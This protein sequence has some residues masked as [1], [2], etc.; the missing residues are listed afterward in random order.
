MR[1]LFAGMLLAASM[2]ASAQVTTECTT[3]AGITRCDTQRNGS[4]P[5]DQSE[6]LRRGMDLVPEYKGTSDAERRQQRAEAL[7]RQV[8]KLVAG[9]DCKGG[10]AAAVKA[11]DFDLAERVRNYCAGR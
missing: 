9:G 10:E 6:A 1:I 5:V 3:M 11:G 2:P 4:A 7:R 8:G